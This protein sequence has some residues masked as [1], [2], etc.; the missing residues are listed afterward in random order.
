MLSRRVPQVRKNDLGRLRS[1]RR[2]C[3]AIGARTPKMH[4][5][6]RFRGHINARPHT[7][8]VAPMTEVALLRRPF[9]RE[10]A[11]LFEPRAIPF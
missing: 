1:T 9:H 4:L 5:H 11:F 3:H 7:T 10:R 6:S 8:M 2:R